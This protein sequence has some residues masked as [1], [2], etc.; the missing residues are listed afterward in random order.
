MARGGRTAK[1]NENLRK[2][3]TAAANIV[4]I[5]SRFAC[6]LLCVYVLC[7]YGDLFIINGVATACS[8]ASI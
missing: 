6:S 1:M 7:S 8:M 5:L 3:N 2:L 4:V